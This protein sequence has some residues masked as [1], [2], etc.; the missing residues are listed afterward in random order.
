MNKRALQ[1][2]P[3]ARLFDLKIDFAFKQLFGS[4]RNQLR[5]GVIASR[6]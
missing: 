5:L 1:R 4:E 3:L 2:I 6:F